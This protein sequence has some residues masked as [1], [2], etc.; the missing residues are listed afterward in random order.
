VRE[1]FRGWRRK[2]GLR[3][4]RF[5]LF[6]REFVRAYWHT[7][8]SAQFPMPPDEPVEETVEQLLA[9][10]SHEIE[11]ESSST[12][13]EP[14]YKL[15]MTSIHGDWWLFSFREARNAWTPIGCLASSDDDEK[16]HDLLGPLYS[17]YFEPF[18][19]HVT[20]IANAQI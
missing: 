10:I 5:E 12:R 8:K 7:V 4:S 14:L 11:I 15:R 17:Q 6:A 16:P 20:A 18:L 19:R 13:S 9:E 1:F 2:V 3:Q